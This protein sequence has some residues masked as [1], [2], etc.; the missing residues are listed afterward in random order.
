MEAVKAEI[1]AIQK[2]G[3][4]KE[5]LEQKKTEAQEIAELVTMS[6][7]Q[8]GR[9][10]KEIP[11]ATPNNN[12]HHEFVQKDNLVKPKAETIRELGFTPKQTSQFQQ[13]AAAL[14]SKQDNR[15]QTNQATNRS[16]PDSFHC[17]TYSGQKVG[18]MQILDLSNRKTAADRLEEVTQQRDHARQMIRER[19][20]CTE[21]IKPAPNHRGDTGYCC[22]SCGSGTHR[23]AASN[24][25]LQFYP[26]TNKVYCHACHWSGDPIDIYMKET[27]ADYNTA[28]S[29]LAER[30]GA[31]LL[32]PADKREAQRPA[33]SHDNSAQD[34]KPAGEDKTPSEGAQSAT[35]TSSADYMAYYAACRERLKDPAAVSYLSARGISYETAYNCWIGYDPAADP[36]SAPGAM[37]NEYKPHACPRII[38]P[39]SKAHYVGRRTDGKDEFAKINAKGSSPRIFNSAILINPKLKYVFVCEGAFD[40]MSVIE[41]KHNAIALNSTSN[42]NLLIDLLEENAQA[43]NKSNAMFILCLDNDDAGKAATETIKEGLRKLEIPFYTGNICGKWKDPNEALVS[44]SEVFSLMIETT[45]SAAKELREIMQEEEPAEELPADEE[46]AEPPTLPGQLTYSAAVN[47]FETADNEIITIKSFPAFSETA[48]IKKHDSFIL[49][50][51]TGAGK[52]SLAINFMNDLN[53][54]YPCIYFNLEMDTID[55]LQRLVSIHT[56]IEL[57]CIEGYQKDQ[58]TAA[59]VNTALKSITDRQPLQIIQGAYLLSAIEDIIEKSTKDRQETT[60]VFLDHSLL[61]DIDKNS[62]SRYDRFTQVSEGLRK[63][64][65]RYNIILFVLLQQNRAGKAAEDERPKNSSL[66]ESGSWEND[67]TQICFL[68]YDPTAKRKKLLLTKNRHGAGGEFVLNYWQKTQTYTEAKDQQAAGATTRQERPAMSKREKQQQRLADCYRAAYTATGGHPTLKAIAEAADVTTTTIKSWIKEYGG[69]TVDGQQIDPAG[70]DTAVEYDGFIKL[71]PAD[72]P[73]F[74]DDQQDNEK[75]IARF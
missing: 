10:M 70:I 22:P 32:P 25:A 63:M 9:M 11:K 2:V 35:A 4:A 16:R 45:L 59:A 47:L 36:A 65:L 21:L 40:A 27:G 52:S 62:G 50:A 14:T 51:D 28:L 30:A 39:T 44:N 6:E 24:G 58:Q 60:I 57:D 20:R 38:I 64:A 34:T 74:E 67:A 48:K 3:L 68:W 41:T 43:G 31:D 69:C 55:V 7:M 12:P 46:P 23:G 71:T 26:D 54:K 1:R 8:I 72:D 66:K 13:K 18:V 5:V 17:N 19:I 33:Q 61:V 29:L 37:G 73:A 56:G 53:E 75:I 42:A 49:A 15:R